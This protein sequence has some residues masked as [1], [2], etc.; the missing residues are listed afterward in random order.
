MKAF[1]ETERKARL[2]AEAAASRV[3]ATLDA[4]GDGKM[5][6]NDVKYAVGHSI[7]VTRQWIDDHDDFIERHFNRAMRAIKIRQWP[8]YKYWGWAVNWM[9]GVLLTLIVLAFLLWAFAP[10]PHMPK[11]SGLQQLVTMNA[12]LD[13]IRATQG[14]LQQQIEGLN[15]QVEQISALIDKAKRM[16]PRERKSWAQQF[17]GGLN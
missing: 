5:T 8:G 4:D 11:I 1:R 16:K 13:E 17:F 15:G 6:L 12:K 3:R 7:G 2:V 14:Q 10:R 9:S